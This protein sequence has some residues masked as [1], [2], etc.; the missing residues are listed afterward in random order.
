MI[1]H[2]L[3][4]RDFT[5]SWHS[6]LITGTQSLIGIPDRYVFI[7]VNISFWQLIL[8]FLKSH[9]NI[10]LRANP[11]VINMKFCQIVLIVGIYLKYF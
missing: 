8:E 3:H 6:N 11:S 2:K 9:K 4:I 5:D 1:F 10:F 7:A